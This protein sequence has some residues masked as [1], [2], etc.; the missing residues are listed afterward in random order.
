[1]TA[2]AL[3]SMR[4]VVSGMPASLPQQ[5]D[6]LAGLADCVRRLDPGTRALLEDRKSVV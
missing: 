4:R 6:P 1:M 3:S 2:D 5:N